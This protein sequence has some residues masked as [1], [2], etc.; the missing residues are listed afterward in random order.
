[1]S[2]GLI[3]NQPKRQEKRKMGTKEVETEQR[4]E[5]ERYFL[6][7]KAFILME[8]GLK[9]KGFIFER[10]FNKFISRFIEMLEKRGWQI[11]GEHKPPGLVALVKEFY[12]IMVGVKGKK[13]YVRGKW[14][15]FSR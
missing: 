11:F 8:K 6:S 7:E 2:L 9:D 12:S 4:N 13:V 15:S 10:G 5:K 3:S 1:M 14:I